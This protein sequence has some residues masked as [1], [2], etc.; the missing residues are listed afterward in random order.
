[1]HHKVIIIDN[2]I[3]ITGSFNFTNNASTDNDENLLVITSH[4][5]AARYNEEFER[6]KNACELTI[7]Q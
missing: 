1:M 5:T 7:L 3:V 2:K 6:V 4:E